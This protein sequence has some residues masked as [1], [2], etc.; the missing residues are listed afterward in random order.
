[1]QDSLNFYYLWSFGG[2]RPR[3]LVRDER[4]AAIC[5]EL[6]NV[7]YVLAYPGID[8]SY[9][10]A[11][12]V[13]QRGRYDLFRLPGEYGYFDVIDPPEV[14]ADAAPVHLRARFER[15]MRAEYP[16]GARFLRLPDPI[17]QGFPGL[18]SAT[19]SYREEQE[20]AE[21][22]GFDRRRKSA[23]GTILAEES[24][25]NR[26][27]ARVAVTAQDAWL[28][29]K[30]TPHPWWHAVVDGEERAVYHLSPAFQGLALEPG[31]HEVVFVFRNPRWQKLLLLMSPLLLAGLFVL[32]FAR[33]RRAER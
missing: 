3:V 10:R 18:P 20:E 7:R 9:L 4:R 6:F 25:T 5:A 12:P 31:E 13:I 21:S 15:W 22:A 24:G 1:V 19:L 2:E 26:Y 27:R 11:T 8:L 32:D 29:L 30:V 16:R 33:G 23:R 14:V 28:V 17:E